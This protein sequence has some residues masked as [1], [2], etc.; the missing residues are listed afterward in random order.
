MDWLRR[1]RKRWGLVTI[2]TGGI[3][4]PKLAAQPDRGN[5]SRWADGFEETLN[6]VCDHDTGETYA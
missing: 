3:F 5:L 4:K 1:I 2:K 6:V